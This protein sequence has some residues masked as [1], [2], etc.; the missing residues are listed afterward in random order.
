MEGWGAHWIV[1]G[2]GVL[3][4]PFTVEEASPAVREALAGWGER[5]LAAAR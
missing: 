3:E 2:L 5:L 1:F 4:A